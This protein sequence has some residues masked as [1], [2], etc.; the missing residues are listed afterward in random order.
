ML[1]PQEGLE[2]DGF[3]LIERLHKGGFATVWSVTHP[4][5][6]EPMVMKVPTILDGYDAP[7]IVGFEIE[8]MILPRL[9]GPHVP[10]VIAIG[11]FAVMPYVVMEWLP[12]GSLLDRMAAAPF[13]VADAVDMAVR[14]A[15]AVASLH[16]QDVLHLDLKPANFL[17]RDDG[18]FVCVDFGLAHHRHVPDLLDEEFSIPMG[19]YPY[20]APEQLL[21]ERG[22]PR[23]DIFALGAIL[24]ELVTGRQPWGEP[25]TL[26]GVRKRLWRRPV[27][28]RALIPTCPEWLQEIILRALEVQ[29]AQRYPSVGQFLFDLRHPYQVQLTER[30]ARIKEDGSWATF[31]RW[32]RMRNTRHLSPPETGSMAQDDAPILMVAVDLSP[33]MEA[34]NQRLLTTITRMLTLQPDARL[35]V[36]NVLKTALIGIDSATDEH[37]DHR[38]VQRLIALRDWGNSLKIDPSRLSFSILEGSD[39]AAVLIQHAAKNHVDHIIVGARGHSATRRFIGSVSAQVV[40]ETNASVTVIRIPEQN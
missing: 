35:L 29:P 4:D 21:R 34:I 23:S 2:V 19:S 3:T 17:V 8:Q 40:A 16:R 6:D 11:D 14:M 39:P 24:Y 13:P 33:A 25:A 32:R 36:V 26:R 27:P 5:H 28:P 18:T 9:E 12:G 31:R 37:G 10:R 20:M 38:H 22:D 7:T 30:A 1:R 15:E